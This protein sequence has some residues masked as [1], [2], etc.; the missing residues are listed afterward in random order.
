[1]QNT[2]KKKLS[3]TY[4]GIF[5]CFSNY[6]QAME[7]KSESFEL[8]GAKKRKQET[9]PESRN[10]ED[11]GYDKDRKMFYYGKEPSAIYLESAPLPLIETDNSVIYG[12]PKFEKS[13]LEPLPTI[14]AQIMPINQIE[15]ILK[16]TVLC[17]QDRRELVDDPHEYP[18][19]AH[20]HM[21]MDYG[22]SYYIGSGTLIGEKYVITAAHNLYDRKSCSIPLSIKFY[23]GMKGRKT[24]Y[25]SEAEYIIFHSRYKNLTNNQV[26][27]DDLGIIKLKNPLGKETGYLG[28]KV[29]SDT[30]LDDIMI[31]ITGYPGD[32]ASGTLMYTMSGPV[33]LITSERI[34][35]DIDTAPGQSGSGIW[36]SED[37][38]YW[39]IGV[40]TY[41]DNEGKE[42]N[43]GT[44]LNLT[45]ARLVKQWMDDLEKRLLEYEISEKAFIHL[46]K[47]DNEWKISYSPGTDETFLHIQ[48]LPLKNL[49]WDTDLNMYYYGEK[50]DFSNIESEHHSREENENSKIQET[51]YF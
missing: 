36:I 19:C 16:E 30:D 5:F 4:V 24:P 41:G 6:A 9:L 29:L 47:D 14:K 45:K 17:N 2:L 27:D 50:S 51:F 3:L 1:M 25:V 44:R 8:H 26:K 40:H 42:L 11:F 15:E 18:W 20:G 21:V 28:L 33:K 23:P 13:E 31:N 7:D 39:I 35:Y 38:E 46:E 22:G 37:G 10:F 34:Y 12:F 43:S 49:K 48:I 32:Y